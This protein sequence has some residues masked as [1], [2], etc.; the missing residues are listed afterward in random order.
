MPKKKIHTRLPS[1]YKA[2]ITL[3]YLSKLD[4][5]ASCA[6]DGR[7]SDSAEFQIRANQIIE[8]LRNLGE[9]DLVSVLEEMSNELGKIFHSNVKPETMRKRYSD[10]MNKYRRADP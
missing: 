10:L 8:L 5:V 4:V 9:N 3:N 6:R 7:F 2:A 1:N